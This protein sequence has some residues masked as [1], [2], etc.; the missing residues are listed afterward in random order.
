MQ[1]SAI[2]MLKTLRI[3]AGVALML[4][5]S[6][7]LIQGGLSR[8]AQYGIPPTPDW[9]WIAVGLVMLALGLNSYFRYSAQWMIPELTT[10]IPTAQ[11]S[12]RLLSVEFGGYVS[13]P[14]CA[15]TW[16]LPSADRPLRRS[17]LCER[18]CRIVH[19]RCLLVHAALVTAS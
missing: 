18:H 4:S 11:R 7:F 1:R 6:G 5:A 9:K 2:L 16:P 12:S 13:L 15:S 17:E 14:V 8:Y 3:T 10:A 19:R